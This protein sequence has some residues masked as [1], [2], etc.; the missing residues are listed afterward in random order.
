MAYCAFHFFQLFCASLMTCSLGFYRINDEGN[1]RSAN[2]VTPQR[3]I[4]VKRFGRLRRSMILRLL[5]KAYLRL[6]K[7]KAGTHEIALGLA[8]G[9][10]I[11]MS[12]TMGIQMPIAVVMAMVFRVSKISAAL[13][14]W[15]TNPVTAPFIYGL[16]Y[17]VGAKLLGFRTLHNLSIHIGLD[18]ITEVFKKAPELLGAMTLGG[19]VLGIPL[20]IAGY[21]IAYKAVEEYQTHL[22][23]KLQRQRERLHLRRLQRQMAKKAKTMHGVHHDSSSDGSE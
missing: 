9:L 15:L 1:H 2:D 3:Q 11:G 13:G 8:L 20:A 14:V 16:N 4:S 23:A 6:I 17:W 12:P 19:T 7:I 22:K 18:S 21:F 5:L 10:F